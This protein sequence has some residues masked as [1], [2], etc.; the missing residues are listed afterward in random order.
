[1]IYTYTYNMMSLKV[2]LKFLQDFQ[3]MRELCHVFFPFLRYPGVSTQH[4][5]LW[6]PHLRRWPHPE[7]SWIHKTTHNSIYVT[8]HDMII[9]IYIHICIYTSVYKHTYIH[10]TYTYIYTYVYIYICIYIIYTSVYTYLYTYT[11]WVPIHL[12]TELEP[13]RPA[14]RAAAAASAWLPSSS[15]SFMSTNSS[16]SPKKDCG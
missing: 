12:F 14:L 13:L 10:I 1:M 15:S 11:Y 5:L 7:M 8:W 16:S 3:A 9:Y 2:V 4:L 6:E